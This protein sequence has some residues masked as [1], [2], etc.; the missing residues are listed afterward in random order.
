MGPGWK[1]CKKSPTT[2]LAESLSF[3]IDKVP[4]NKVTGAGCHFLVKIMN[5]NL[6]VEIE[7]LLLALV[8]AS[9]SDKEAAIFLSMYYP[10]VLARNRCET[11]H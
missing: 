2:S 11:K 8:D 6:G 4:E 3:G 10:W 5:T 9:K 1:S 7:E